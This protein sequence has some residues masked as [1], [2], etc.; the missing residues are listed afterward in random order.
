MAQVVIALG[1][2][3]GDRRSHLSKARQFL[4]ELGNGRMLQSSI[5][6]TEPVGETST[7]WY[8]NAI[9]CFETRLK[10]LSLLESLK[11]YETRHG[12]DPEAPPW[13]N[14]TID[15]DI[16]DYDRSKYARQRLLVPHPEYHKRRFVLAPLQEVLPDWADLQT[17]KPID[18]LIDQAPEIEV[19]KKKLNW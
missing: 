17:G 16:I 10:P 14:R 2:N 12:R 6:E 8:Y 11:E 19:F 18:E 1:S 15:L 4:A 3:L 9:C 7:G 5:Y 13:S